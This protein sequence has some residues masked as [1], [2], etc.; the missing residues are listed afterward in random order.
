MGPAKFNLIIPGALALIA[1]VLCG[2]IVLGFV[3]WRERAGK[4]MVGLGCGF[5]GLLL[6]FVALVVGGALLGF[7]VLPP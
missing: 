7:R 5:L 6:A 3:R 1:L 2:V 4:V